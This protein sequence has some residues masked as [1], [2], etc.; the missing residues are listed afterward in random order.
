MI[1]LKSWLS[2]SIDEPYTGSSMVIVM[3]IVGAVKDSDM[4][5]KKTYLI[6]YKT[7]QLKFNLH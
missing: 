5:Y 3:T 6:T 4:M 1:I 7:L 2:D